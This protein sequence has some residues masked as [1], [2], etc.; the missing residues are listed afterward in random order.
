MPTAFVPLN[1]NLIVKI[2]KKSLLDNREGD[3]VYYH[4]SYVWYTRNLQC[5]EVVAISPVAK[6]EMKDVNIGDLLIFHH[7]IEASVA[8]SEMNSDYMV[9]ED[10]DYS[11]FNVSAKE[12]PGGMTMA[13]A[14]IKDGLIV[15]H[16]DYVFLEE[17]VP[18]KYAIDRQDALN[19]MEKVKNR[20]LHLM[21]TSSPSEHLRTSVRRAEAENQKMTLHL[22]KK[23]TIPFVVAFASPDK[24][25]SIGDTICT[26]NMASNV[27]VSV[28]NIDYRV[29]ESRF[30]RAI[31]QPDLSLK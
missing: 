11:Y 22:N 30:V 27:T 23:L 26:F 19:K 14:V 21:H 24:P 18:E 7:Y 13:Y 5:G 28:N 8:M 9:G 10:A 4:Q 1:P 15:P 31:F 17:Q 6:S 2:A 29:V 16:K 12:N 25:Y 3:K 20:N